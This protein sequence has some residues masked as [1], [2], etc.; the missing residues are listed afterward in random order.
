MDS[1]IK[2]FHLNELNNEPLFRIGIFDSQDYREC[3]I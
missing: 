1:E 3:E 2:D